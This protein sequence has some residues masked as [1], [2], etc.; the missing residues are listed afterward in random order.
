MSI[1][2]GIVGY[3]NLGRGVEQ[4]ITKQPDME[5]RGVF[6]RRD[7]ASVDTASGVG[8]FAYDDLLGDASPELDVLILCGGSRSDLPVQTPELAARYNVIDSF[9]THARIPEHFEAV[10]R[11]AATTT[12]I[13]SCGW[14]PGLFS[15][16]RIYAEA[17]LLD[18]VTS[19]FWGKGLSQGHSDA[20]RR[21]P[22]VADGV[23]YTIP[24]EAAMAA[25]RAG[26]ASGASATSKHTR[27][28]YVVAE[29]GADI[30]EIRTAIT[31][32]PDYFAD[33]DTTVEFITA[34]E[35]ARD[36]QAMPHGGFVIHSGHTSP[37]NQ[38]VIEYSLQLGSN[39]EFTAS[40]LVA[41]ARA[42]YRLAQQG[43]FGALTPFDVAPGL[44]HPRDATDLRK[45][46]L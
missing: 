44:L 23:Q 1:R 4:A 31:T 8:V 28:C 33:Y 41:Y 19:T 6:T 17:V 37:G 42:A 38:Q 2:I 25:A 45:H 43:T 11:T 30:E 10:S 21:V 27:H 20:V 39:P 9:D 46:Y 29:P 36:H 15:I 40:V 32:M 35:L 22:G 12:A 34:E 18:G 13:I 14:D 5:L 26:E 16:N 3:G 7:P 24:S